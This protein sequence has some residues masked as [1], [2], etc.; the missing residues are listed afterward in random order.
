V[1]QID[2]NI[3]HI[4]GQNVEIK[5]NEF[6]APNKDK[7]KVFTPRGK[8][9]G[10]RL[11]MVQ[12]LEHVAEKF[13]KGFSVKE[14]SE[15]LG[16]DS[17]TIGKY[18]KIISAFGQ[19]ESQLVEI[20][21]KTET[22]YRN[23]STNQMLDR[24]ECI[25]WIAQ[26]K[27]SGKSDGGRGFANLLNS[28]CKELQI[29][30]LALCQ[31]PI[32]QK[33]RQEGLREIDKLMAKVKEGKSESQF[34]AR[35]MAVR[36]WINFNG[37]SLPRGNLCPV[38]LHGRVVSSHG[39]YANV[40]LT[41]DQLKKIEDGF[42]NKEIKF[43]HSDLSD[44]TELVYR[45]GM[46]T[47]SRA[48]AILTCKL[49]TVNKG[50][51]NDFEIKVIERKLTHVGNQN[52]TKM[53]LDQKLQKL[54]IPR[55]EAGKECLIGE[56]NQY[57]RYEDME[58][59]KTIEVRRIDGAISK[60]HDNLR[61]LYKHAGVTE[62]YFYDHPIHSLRHAGCQNLL[63]ASGWNTSLVSMIG[64]WLSTIEVEKSYGKMP[65]D[66]MKDQYKDA[67]DKAKL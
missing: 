5:D 65:P 54:I 61:A 27:R 43:P 41:K 66:I 49:S 4:F 58:K 53:I 45:F 31:L 2:K 39:D 24:P 63:S 64:G 14:I 62:P 57:V 9:G 38:N 8:I 50:D 51:S 48:L 11:T 55:F 6:E 12:V 19:L 60:L 13:Q 23:E 21:E 36:N 3:I 29:T 35:R 59:T 40:R 7:F 30:P 25:E 46:A 33:D 10:R 44:D 28:V 67:F 15:L 16:K 32:Y 17:D 52:Q 1:V 20:K 26:L 42:S 22:K 34:Y 47:M 56:K 37:V 18:K